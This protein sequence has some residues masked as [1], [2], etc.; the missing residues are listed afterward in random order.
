MSTSTKHV[1][2]TLDALR[3]IAATAVVFGHFHET[4]FRANGFLAVDLFFVMSGVVIAYSYE[5]R[6]RAGM[7]VGA[8]MRARLIRLYPLYALATALALANFEMLPIVRSNWLGAHPNVGVAAETGMLMLP[9]P[10]GVILYPLL[11]P[12]WSLFFEI[13][14]N[15]AYAAALPILTM[16]RLVIAVAVSAVALAL[17]DYY[18]GTINVGWAWGNIFGG[19]ARVGFGFFFG[20]T[21]YRM[22]NRMKLHVPFWLPIAMTGV[23]LLVPPGGAPRQGLVVFM[24]TPLIVMFGMNAMPVGMSQKVSGLLGATSY[25]IYVLH[26][27]V[28]TMALWLSGGRYGWPILGLFGVACAAIDRAYDIPVRRLLSGRGGLKP[29]AA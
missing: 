15:A 5:E 16:R 8:F 12:A 14:A 19:F 7:T 18:Y 13:V 25:A 22:R 11:S 24:V 6:L 26:V 21:I 28:I 10:E 9:N 20:V 17:A 23:V 29:R 2:L 1:Y 27:P 4:F 3:G